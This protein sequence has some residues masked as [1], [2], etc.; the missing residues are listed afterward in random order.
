MSTEEILEAFAGR[1][2]VYGKHRAFIDR[3]R[4]QSEKFSAAVIEKVTLEHEIK[5]AEEADAILA[6][7]PDLEAALAALAAERDAIVG[8]QA[9]ATAAMEELSLR[10]MIGELDDEAFEAEAKDLK[11]QLGASADNVADLETRMTAISDALGKWAELASSAGQDPGL[12]AAD[13]DAPEDA[14]QQ[15]DDESSAE[16]AVEIGFGEAAADDDAPPGFGSD[17]PPGFE[18]SGDAADDADYADDDEDDV[19]DDDDYA[20]EDDADDVDEDDADDDDEDDADDEVEE[21]ASEEEFDRRR[22][23]V[24]Y[25]EGTTEEQFYPFTG[26]DLTIGRGRENDIQ[27]KNDSK[28]SRYHCRIFRRNAHFFIEDNK[29]SN[30]TLKNGANIMAEGGGEPVRLFGGEEIMVGETFFRFRILD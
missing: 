18:D 10:Q 5:S 24:I 30:G 27:I 17:A 28:V 16:D 26:D 20:D 7:V 12:S 23:L 9:G 4:G 3:A 25:E 8:G 14:E 6:L 29:S 15:V 21:A 2:E 19:D 1:L 11:E 22:A 13:A